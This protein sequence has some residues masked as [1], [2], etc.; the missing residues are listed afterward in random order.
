M[1]GIIKKYLNK[2]GYLQI[3]LHLRSLFWLLLFENAIP[4]NT[5]FWREKILA[6]L[7][8]CKRITEIYLSKIFSFKKLVIQIY[9][10][11]VCVSGVD[12]IVEVF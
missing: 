3:L 5:R 4:Y 10:V 1:L 2:T 6:N 12:G 7:V 8:N 9:V 11:R